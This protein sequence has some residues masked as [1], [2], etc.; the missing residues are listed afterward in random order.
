MIPAGGT[1]MPLS[2]ELMD[3]GLQYFHMN[4]RAV[5]DFAI[6]AFP[7]AV[8]KVLEKCGLGVEDV[9]LIVPHQANINIIKH[10][11]D[12]LGL[13]MDKAYTNLDRYGNIAGG[14]IPIALDEAVKQGRVED[15][16]LV[17]LVGYG[18]GLAWGA[19]AIRWGE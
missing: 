17:V 14:S 3:K 4:G 7:E 16:D 18:G 10:S 2:H 5:W 12:S 19:N 8:L 9:D 1:R 6:E 13:P 15:G 11:M